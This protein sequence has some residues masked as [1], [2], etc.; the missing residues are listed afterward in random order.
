[1]KF[2]LV[3]TTS[4]M[5]SA[6]NQAGPVTTPLGVRRC[7]STERPAERCAPLSMPAA[8][9]RLTWRPLALAG[10]TWQRRSPEA[11]R[12]QAAPIWFGNRYPGC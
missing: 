5:L 11:A 1:M 9:T 3:S 7:C 8:S 12:R 2:Q 4:S 6:W 10:L